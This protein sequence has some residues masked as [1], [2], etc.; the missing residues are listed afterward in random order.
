M[1]FARSLATAARQRAGRLFTQMG[2][3]QR[4]QS[5]HSASTYHDQR[6]VYRKKRMPKGRR[7]RWKKFRNKVLAVSEKDLGSRTHLFNQTYTWTN[8]TSGMNGIANAGLY[9]W[10]SVNGPYADLGYLAN[11]ENVADPTAALGTT[12]DKTTK[13]IFKSAIMD[14]TITNQSGVSNGT[15]YGSD[16]R[17][18]LE[19]D[20]YEISASRDFQDGAV[21][22]PDLTSAFTSGA[23]NT[24]LLATST[25][26]AITYTAGAAAGGGTGSCTRGS[27]PWDLPMALSQFGIKIWKKRKY[28]VPNNQTITYQVRDAKRHVLTRENMLET[29]GGNFPKLT[30]WV[31][32]VY[33]LVPGL[34]V[35]AVGVAGNWQ[36]SIAIG[37]TRKYFYKI[38]GA[39]EDRDCVDAV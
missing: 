20:I 1:G 5:G 3:R 13:M 19:V 31:F 29:S 37:Q 22:Y 27:T 11:G 17:G 4:L 25:G 6:N 28:F 15:V 12:V 36:E 9:T 23:T 21:V 39:N 26:T 7:R 24:K 34:S 35:G 16:S 8:N 32:I 30:K 14:L 2:K 18:I 33:K 38:E 10:R